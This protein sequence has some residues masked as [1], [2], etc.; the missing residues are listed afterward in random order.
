MEAGEL[1]N[2]ALDL[3]DV[4]IDS[5]DSSVSDDMVTELERKGC[6]TCGSCSGMFTANSMNC[7]NEAIGLALPGNGTI[8]ATH[9]NR[10]ELFKKAAKMIVENCHKYY[11]NEDDS[12]LPRSIATRQAMLNAI[13]LDI[14]MGGSTNTILHLLAIAHEADVHFNMKD[15]DGLSRKT[16]VLCK[17]APNAKYHIQDV[18]RAGGIMSIMHQLSKNGNLDTSVKSVDGL[19][20]GDAIENYS[21][22]GTSFRSYTEPL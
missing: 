20:L 6:P 9:K 17:V 8:V 4:M 21:I 16:P 13:T 12:V 3:I 7:L 22:E 2:R 5:A 18:N 11:D 10:T 15:I 14:A 19:T 1:G